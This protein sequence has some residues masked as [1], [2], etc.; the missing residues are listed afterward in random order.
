ML[1][2]AAGLDPAR[3]AEYYE[4]QGLVDQLAYAGNEAARR[5]INRRSTRAQ[6]AAWLEK[7]ALMQHDRAVQ[8]VKF[9]DQY[10]SYVI[11]YNLGQG[12]G[13]TV[14]RVARRHG[15]QARQALGGIREAVVVSATALGPAA[16]R[17]MSRL[18]LAFA[19]AASIAGYTFVYGTGRAETA[20]PV[21]RIQLLRLPAVLVHLSR[22]VAR[23]DGAR[24]LRRRIPGVHGDHPLAGHAAMGQRAPDWRRGHA[25]ATLRRGARAD[26]LDEPV[27]RRFQLYY[28]HAAGLSGTL[29]MLA[30]LWVLRGAAAPS[31]QRSRHGRSRC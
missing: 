23:R 12:H 8:R 2:P 19:A 15:G 18:V 28:Q 20:D 10:R 1:F 16:D 31:F 14:H 4:V 26:A 24:L 17:R 11:N 6:A 3:A 27:A 9:F 7:Y 22:P 29:W 21:G 13:A 5:Y 30:G 25:G